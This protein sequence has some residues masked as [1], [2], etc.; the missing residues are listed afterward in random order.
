MLG[1]SG[2]DIRRSPEGEYVFL[3]CNPCPMF[4]HF[5]TVTGY[6]IS[7]RLVD[8]LLTPQSLY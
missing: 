4:M 3:E 5:E 6:P 7:D 1:Y 8:L 2:I